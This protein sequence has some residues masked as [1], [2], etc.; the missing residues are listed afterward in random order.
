MVH[1][2]NDATRIGQAWGNENYDFACRSSLTSVKAIFTAYNHADEVYDL[3]SRPKVN[4][5]VGVGGSED[6]HTMPTTTPQK[7]HQHRGDILSINL[8]NEVH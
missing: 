8:L 4:M 3:M 6:T 7:G 2:W 1:T 5:L